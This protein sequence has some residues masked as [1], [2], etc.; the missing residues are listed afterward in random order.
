MSDVNVTAYIPYHQQLRYFIENV[1]QDDEKYSGFSVIETEKLAGYK[2][3]MSAEEVQ[4]LYD[5]YNKEFNYFPDM[6]TDLA[7]Q[8]ELLFTDYAD[9]EEE[10]EGKSIETAD[11]LEYLIEAEIPIDVVDPHT[12]RVV[13]LLFV[14]EEEEQEELSEETV[15][16]DQSSEEDFEPIFLDK[17]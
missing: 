9:L 4:T 1:L 5:F 8:G 2:N 14:D 16:E 12:G 15:E 3:S 6:A 11:F 7:R 13:R 10:F 17:N